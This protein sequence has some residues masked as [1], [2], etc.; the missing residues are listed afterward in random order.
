MK[1]EMTHNFFPDL[2]ERFDETNPPSWLVSREFDWWYKDYVLVLK[3][4][5]SIKSDFRKITRIE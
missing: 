2:M 1:F 4:G 5:E 3:V